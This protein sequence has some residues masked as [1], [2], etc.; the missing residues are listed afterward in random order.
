[1]ELPTDLSIIIPVSSD[2]TGLLT[3]L[4]S[5]QSLN[6]EN[7]N[8][9]V[10]VCNDGGGER[11]S[12]IIESFS[13]K[14]AKLKTNCG[15]YA[16]R[17]E[18]ISIAQGWALAFV[19]A[20]EILAPDW[21]QHGIRALQQADYVGGQIIVVSTNED[22]WTS[23]DKKFAFDVPRQLADGF[24]PTANLFVKRSVFD[25]VGPFRPELKSGGDYE[26]GLRVR[27]SKFLQAFEEKAVTYHPARSRA[28][29]IQK[30]RRIAGGMSEIK[31][32]IQGE[33]WE[34]M[35]AHAA[36]RICK[37]PA[38]LIWRLPKTLFS[39]AEGSSTGL[40]P[41][42]LLFI[43]KQKK[44]IRNYWLMLTAIQIGGGRYQ[45]YQEHKENADA[46]ATRPSTFDQRR[47]PTPKEPL[48]KPR[49]IG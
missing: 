28:Q 17:N 10:I 23:Y 24:A 49:N 21:A 44:L 25:Q 46:Q 36:L 18:G 15:S 5:I 19:D 48:K 26:F 41:L 8:T 7:I 31:I 30:L 39:K 43:S 32:R 12:T 14:E 1:V 33:P 38:E 4:R 47:P 2:V 40:S 9:E 6:L 37:I 27:E 22:P 42:K 20:D 45:S 29:Q 35:A 3:T 11:I 34:K 16:A 13:Y